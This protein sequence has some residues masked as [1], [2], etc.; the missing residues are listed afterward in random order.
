MDPFL[1]FCM[2]QDVSLQKKRHVQQK[3]LWKYMYVVLDLC[4]HKK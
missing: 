1:L 3:V 4:R 2:V